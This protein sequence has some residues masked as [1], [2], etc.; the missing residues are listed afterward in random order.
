MTCG[1]GGCCRLVYCD[2]QLYGIHTVRCAKLVDAQPQNSASFARVPGRARCACTSG[3]TDDQLPEKFAGKVQ[4]AI[5]MP[6]FRPAPSLLTCHPSILSTMLSRQVIVSTLLNSIPAMGSI[7]LLL[8]LVSCEINIAAIVELSPAMCVL[9]AARACN[10]FAWATADVFAIMGVRMFCETLPSKFG[11]MYTASF[12]LFQLITLDDW[13]ELYDDIRATE[14]SD[15]A[16]DGVHPVFLYFF[17]FIVT[18][19]FIFV[20][21]FTAVIVNNL[22]IHQQKQLGSGTL[23]SRGG[24]DDAAGGSNND[25]SAHGPDACAPIQVSAHRLAIRNR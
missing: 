11:S 18:E 23:T 19:N 25:A 8:F 5:A 10:G 2:G 4:F 12:T 24:G 9:T 17:V 22:E 14:A 15:G 7:I 20:N 1:A 3:F 13:F 6:C 21:L 16:H